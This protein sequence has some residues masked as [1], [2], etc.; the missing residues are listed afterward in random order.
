[1]R[2]SALSKMCWRWPVP[3]GSGVSPVL[4][5]P[6]SGE[7]GVGVDPHGSGQGPGNHS[8]ASGV[9]EGVAQGAVLALEEVLTT[10]PVADRR[11]ARDDQVIGLFADHYGGLCRLATL[12]LSD[13]VAAEEIVQEA[14]LRTFASWW[15][16]RQP[17]QAQ[18]YL[19][20]TV[21]NLCRSRIRRARVE[22]T[23]NR[24][25]WALVREAEHPEPSA[26][27]RLVLDAVA[28]LPRR[29]REAVVLR[30][31]EDMSEE[32]VS[33]VLGCSIGTV[34]SQL[35]K[36]RHTLAGVLGPDLGDDR[37]S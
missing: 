36:A 16:L 35:S 25:T 12:L 2:D 11:S 26:D 17:A 15:R 22:D 37:D 9:Y 5:P 14:F 31:Y 20:R 30:Y 1:M 19:R 34:K 10:E 24:K 23:S 4:T 8:G 13:S 6:L 33:S 32:Q 7:R 28:G 21:V 27:Q 29:Q 18:W 3:E